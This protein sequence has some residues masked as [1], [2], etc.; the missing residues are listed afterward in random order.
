VK[1]LLEG[2][3]ELGRV[4]ERIDSMANQV[5]GEIELFKLD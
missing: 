2:I 1:I 3:G 4:A 5:K